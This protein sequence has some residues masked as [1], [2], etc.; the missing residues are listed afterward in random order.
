[1]QTK[2]LFV[3]I[4]I[5]NKVRLA[6]LNLF[7]PS[8]FL[9]AVQ[10]RYFFCGSFLLFVLHVCHSVLSA[11]CSLLITCW[12]SA[13]VLA[14]SCVIISSVFV[15]FPYGILGQVWYLMVPIPDLC[16]LPCFNYWISFAPVFI[17][18]YC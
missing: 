5:I 7:K 11:P 6:P 13:D 15:T 14:L 9:L 2:H 10:R 8:I 16:L 3:L 12:K 4:H 17:C 1:M 18:T